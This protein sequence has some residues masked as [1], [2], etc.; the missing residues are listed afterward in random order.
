MIKF[1]RKI[2]Q[3]L[4]SEGKTGKYIKYAIGEIVLVVIGIL[5]ALSINNW[6][7]MRKASIVEIEILKEIKS[8]L[9][10][11]LDN[12]KGNSRTQNGILRS[13]SLILN[14]IEKDLDY[15]DS[16]SRHFRNAT[17]IGIFRP[18]ASTFESLKQMG[19]RTITN[20]SLRNKILNLYENEYNSHSTIYNLLIE[21]IDNLSAISYKFFKLEGQPIL[22]F[23]LI[24]ENKLKTND[25]YIYKLIRM[26][27]INSRYI[28]YYTPKVMNKI[29]L[30]LNAIDEELKNK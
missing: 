24:D 11:D 19:L 26:T 21:E 28:N 18:N 15:E 8:S 30:T 9:Q 14:W 5:I 20:D 4:L 13:Q 12:L 16:L 25:E 2:R 3:N 7:E 6:N 23:T 1:F 22:K 27:D 10:K 29:S 17:N